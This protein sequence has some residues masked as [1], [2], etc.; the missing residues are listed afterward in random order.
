MIKISK[1]A[2]I[3]FLKENPNATYLAL[4]YIFLIFYFKFLKAFTLSS[5]LGCVDQML[6]F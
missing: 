2:R 3:L 4:G 5:K 1:T 6:D